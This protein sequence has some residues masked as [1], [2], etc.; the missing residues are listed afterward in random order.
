MFATVLERS[1]K[2]KEELEGGE[3][4]PTLA[5]LAED[6]EAPGEACSSDQIRKPQHGRSARGA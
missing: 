6:S 2:K 5:H 1:R 4:R 3:Q